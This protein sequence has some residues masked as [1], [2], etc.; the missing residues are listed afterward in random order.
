M[1][2]HSGRN[3]KV[4]IGANFLP[5]VV[6]WDIAEKADTVKTTAMGEEWDSH[7]AT[8]K[9]WSGSL[10]LRA[11]HAAGSYQT[12]RAGDTVALELYSEGDATGQT[13]YTGSAI[14]TDNGIDVPYDNEVARK[15]SFIGSGAL[16]VDVV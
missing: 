5:D 4:K 1:A 3:G 9:N 13:F 7:L 12:A 8:Q 6:S 15:Y 16:T 14:L 10:T 11:N 2:R